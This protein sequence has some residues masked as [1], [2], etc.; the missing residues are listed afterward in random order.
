MSFKKLLLCIAAA[1]VLAG[2]S[3]KY[4]VTQADIDRTLPMPA[5]LKEPLAGNDYGI[6]RISVMNL[7]EEPAY[8]AEMG[9]QM[10]MGAICW[11][12][13]RKDGWAMVTTPDGYVAWTT[14][15]S[16]VFTDGDGA[17][18]WKASKRLIVTAHHTPLLAAPRRSADIVRDAVRGCIVAC[19]GTVGAYYR[20]RLPDGVE[21][22][23][24]KRAVADCRKYFEKQN[25]FGADI[26]SDAKLYMGVPYMW[27]G[28]SVKALDCSGLAQRTY[29]DCGILLPRNAS[30]QAQVG[31]VVDI[32][33]G[34]DNLRQGDL[35]FFG[36]T[37]ADGS[38]G[39]YHVAIYIGDSLFIHSAGGLVHVNSLIPGRDNYF[40]GVANIVSARRII[41]SEDATG[42]S[43]VINNG[44]YF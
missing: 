6:C 22:Y 34:W 14:E 23:V 39:V 36:R 42:S 35:L 31:D 25:P 11:V 28:T 8:E 27:A 9:T 20:C 26:V 24:A 12:I 29:M 1:A 19:T 18:A 10:L 2:C 32:G 13:E 7:R 17:M 21:C 38:V 5:S 33:C 3:Q 40:S 44:W 30:Q 16:L 4:A 15:G 41:G 43:L 37:R